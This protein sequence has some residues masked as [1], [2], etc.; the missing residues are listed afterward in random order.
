MT[1]SQLLGRIDAHLIRMDAHLVR[2]DGH[3]VRMDTHLERSEELIGEVREEMRL[4]REAH[5]DLRSFT[6][7]ITR[8]NEIVM[9]EMVDKLSDLGDQTRANTAAVLQ[10]L[11]RLQ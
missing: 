3:L 2:M 1:E 7:E 10:V 8:R 4:S 6:R 5:A 11:D 9:G